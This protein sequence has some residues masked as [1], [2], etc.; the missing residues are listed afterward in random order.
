M[1]EFEKIKFA[2]YTRKSG[3]FWSG[4]V[5][6]VGKE[7]DPGS[8]LVDYRDT[9]DVD[10]IPIRKCGGG[11]VAKRQLHEVSGQGRICTCTPATLTHVSETRHT[12]GQGPLSH[13]QIKAFIAP[14]GTL[15]CDSIRTLNC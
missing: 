10:E 8:V 9:R 2:S 15:I 5:L 11:K 4:K 14:E 6:V 3:T 12:S 13:N 7:E 1:F